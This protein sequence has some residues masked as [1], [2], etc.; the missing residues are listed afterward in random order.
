MKMER[1][2][3]LKGDIYK[4]IHCK[5]CRFAYS[6]EPDK[7]GIGKHE[8]VGGDEMLYEGMVQACPAGIQYGWEAYWNAGKVWIARALLEG[9]LNFEEHGEDI[10]DVIYPCIT[11]GMC[12]AQCE[13]QVRTV[14]IIEALR[15]AT[16]E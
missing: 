11:C 4:C 1:L 9:E 7:K 2:E 15:A 8:G 14:E 12:G 6:G 3:E 5:A 13:N 10:A 16:M